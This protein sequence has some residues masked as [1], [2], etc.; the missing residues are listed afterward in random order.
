MGNL[1]AADTEDYGNLA[2]REAVKRWLWS[3]VREVGR[4]FHNPE[5]VKI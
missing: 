2:Q 4:V 1:L 3:R 5:R